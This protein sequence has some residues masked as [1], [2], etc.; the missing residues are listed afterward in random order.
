MDWVQFA[1]QWLHVIFAVF[2]FGGTMYFDFVVL[3]TLRQVPPLTGREVGRALAKRIPLF[4]R[5]A[6]IVVIVLGLLRGT[7]WGPLPPGEPSV[8]FG[9][10]YGITWSISILLAVAIFAVGD[11]MIG[12]SARRLYEDDALWSFATAGGPPSAGFLALSSRMRTFSLV[13]LALFLAV[14]TCMIL[15]RFGL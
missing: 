8:S 3:P 15:M 10:D 1:V 13:Q 14:F 7:V 11:G 2:W 4:M 5:T 12:R 9:S 6:G